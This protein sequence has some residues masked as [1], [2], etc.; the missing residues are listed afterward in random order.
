M[1]FAPDRARV[2]LE[3]IE[4]VLGAPPSRK[5][6]PS[7]SKEVSALPVLPLPVLPPPLPTRPPNSACVRVRSPSTTAFRSPP[8]QNARP[9]PV[10]MT[11]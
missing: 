1:P 5:I 7:L 9:A 10:K 11:T 3:R 2:S 8:A 6:E 4:A